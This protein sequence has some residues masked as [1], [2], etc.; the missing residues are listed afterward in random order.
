MITKNNSCSNWMLK[1]KG[2]AINVISIPCFKSSLS[3]FSS[4]FTYLIHH[5]RCAPTAPITN[6]TRHTQSVVFPSTSHAPN[7]VKVSIVTYEVLFVFELVFT[8]CH[9]SSLDTPRTSCC[10]RQTYSSPSYCNTA[11]P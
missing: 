2:L 7:K 10:I 8:C 5:F 9:A 11:L 4:I 6:P 3:V 1:N